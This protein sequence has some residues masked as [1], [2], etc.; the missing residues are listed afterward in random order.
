MEFNWN[1]VKRQRGKVNAQPL[2]EIDY[3]VGESMKAH[4]EFQEV[5]EVGSQFATLVPTRLIPDEPEKVFETVKE[6]VDRIMGLLR[7]H[8]IGKI[9]TGYL[10]NGKT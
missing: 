9:I 3:G 10:N 5:Q 1:V 2:L 4:F 6:T 7:N 8:I